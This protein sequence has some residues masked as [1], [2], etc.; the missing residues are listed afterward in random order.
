MYMHASTR[1]TH[2][3]LAATRTRQLDSEEDH[4]EIGGQHLPEQEHQEIGDVAVIAFP[5]IVTL[6][7]HTHAHAQRNNEGRRD[8]NWVRERTTGGWYFTLTTHCTL[9]DPF[10]P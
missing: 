7:I 9:L 5:L 6:H 1:H 8:R 2:P 4:Y 10:H 3:S